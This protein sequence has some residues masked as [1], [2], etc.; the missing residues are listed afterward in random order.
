VH[1]S[2]GTGHALFLMCDD[3]HAF[4]TEMQKRKIECGPVQDQGWGV[5]TEVTLPSS[6]KLHVYRP[7]HKRPKNRGDR[8]CTWLSS[9]RDISD[10]DKEGTFLFAVEGWPRIGFIWQRDDGP[11]VARRR[12]CR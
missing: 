4:V 3:I 9:E 2:E 6:G 7:R 8:R 11:V 10:N 1:Q 12:P 5:L